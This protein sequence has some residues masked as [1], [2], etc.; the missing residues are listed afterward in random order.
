[1]LIGES[2]VGEGA[3][4]AHVNTVLGDRDG[5]VGAA[6]AIALATPGPGHTP[7]IA[8]LRPGLPAKP[9]TLFVNKA[10]VAGS[11]HGEL[12]WGAAQA[13]VAAGVADAVGEGVVSEA[14]ADALL[15]IAAVW[16]NPA[17]KDADKVYA[18][19]RAA[20]KQ[21][22]RAGAE[23]LPRVADV[24]GAADRPTNPFYTA[25]PLGEP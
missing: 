3:E 12:T 23:R 1:M 7:F 14:D 24:L 18:N 13:G 2:F 22:L 5:P 10:T 4:A 17:A 16:V 9:M 15:L 25:P 8:V 11:G 21:A 19:N 20:T 6:W